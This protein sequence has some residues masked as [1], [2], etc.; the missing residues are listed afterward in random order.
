MTPGAGPSRLR[1]RRVTSRAAPAL[2]ES[3]YIEVRDEVK[4]IDAVLFRS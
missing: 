1:Q 3:T 2:I 4:W